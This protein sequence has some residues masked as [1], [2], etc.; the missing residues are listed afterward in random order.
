LVAEDRD[1]VD[2]CDVD[3]VAGGVLRHVPRRGQIAVTAFERGD[4]RVQSRRDEE[5]ERGEHASVDL[6]RADVVAAA[7]IDVDVRVGQ[8][9]LLSLP[10]RPSTVPPITFEPFLRRLSS[11]SLGLSRNTREK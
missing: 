3:R 7:R 1:V 8:G 2:L 9:T 4:G 6:A 11:T 5:L 10:S